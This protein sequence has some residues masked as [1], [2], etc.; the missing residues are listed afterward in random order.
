[1]LESILAKIVEIDRVILR[2][3]EPDTSE[4]AGM[5]GS[6]RKS[7]GEKKCYILAVIINL[8]YLF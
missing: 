2:K 1:M 4:A 3:T 6:R 7:R 5:T 8:L